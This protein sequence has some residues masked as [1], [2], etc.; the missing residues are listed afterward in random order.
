MAQHAAPAPP[1]LRV[2]FTILAEQL[3]ALRE[4]IAGPGMF[5]RLVS[6]A[7]LVATLSSQL[8]PGGECA[9]TAARLDSALDDLAFHHAQHQDLARQTADLVARALTMLAEGAAVPARTLTL[10]ALSALYVSD[11]QRRL[12]DAVVAEHAGRRLGE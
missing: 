12:H 7:E 6:C 5:E 3:A 8:P 10:S 4:R 9:A 2:I 1:E 11:D